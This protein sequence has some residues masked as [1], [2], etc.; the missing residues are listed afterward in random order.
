MFF[1]FEMSKERD[2]VHF[3]SLG[4]L[5]GGRSLNSSSGQDKTG[6]VDKPLPGLIDGRA[7]RS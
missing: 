3:S 2:F 6:G 1:A 5:S 4:N 7:A